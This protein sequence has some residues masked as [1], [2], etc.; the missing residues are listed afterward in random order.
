MR[1]FRG[2]LGINF[3]RVAHFPRVRVIIDI[4]HRTLSIICPTYSALHGGDERTGWMDG[5]KIPFAL[6]VERKYFLG[7]N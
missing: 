4:K 5:W 1:F 3:L 7:T 2:F 6:N